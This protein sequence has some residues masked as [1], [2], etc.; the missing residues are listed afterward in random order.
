MVNVL[1]F[2]TPK[3][4]TKWHMQT[5]YTP[6]RLLLQEHSDQGLHCLPF[7]ETIEEKANLEPKN[8]WHKVFR[9]LKH[10]PYSICKWHRTRSAC[11]D[12]QA[13]L[14]LCYLYIA[15]GPFS[16]ICR[17][18]SFLLVHMSNVHIVFYLQHIYC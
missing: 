18:V 9:I 15:L 5:V 16:H 1:N 3:F 13:D 4:L 11:S 8:V 10:S 12:M 17:L 2:K 7:W 14:G 6:I